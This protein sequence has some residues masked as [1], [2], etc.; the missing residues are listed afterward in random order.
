MIGWSGEEKKDT[1][2]INLD[3]WYQWY[4]KYKQSRNS[5]VECPPYKWEVEI[6]KFSVTTKLLTRSTIG[7]AVHS[8]CK[9]CRFEPYR[10]SQTIGA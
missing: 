7:R 3:I 8:E 6:A 2:Q 5:E 9:G 10:V 4:Y 1:F